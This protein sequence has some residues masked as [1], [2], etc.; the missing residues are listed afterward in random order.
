LLRKNR[1]DQQEEL[2]L[3]NLILAALLLAPVAATA[4]PVGLWK[5]EPSDKGA[6]LYVNIKQCNANSDRLCGWITK[7]VNATRTDL[8]GKVML[9]NMRPKGD[10]RWSKG[11]IWAPDDDKTYKA[12]MELDGDVL[13]VKGCVVIFC[14]GQEWTRVE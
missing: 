14:R 12:K 11:T 10:N 13:E 5:T 1:A 6:Y 9:K 8:V 7:A 4:Q 3:R 2:D